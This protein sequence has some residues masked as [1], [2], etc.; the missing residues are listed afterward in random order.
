[1]LKLFQCLGKVGAVDWAPDPIIRAE[2]SNGPFTI[3]LS[4]ITQMSDLCSALTIRNRIS[5]NGYKLSRA[6]DMG[7]KTVTKME[8]GF[9]RTGLISVLNGF[10]KFYLCDIQYIDWKRNEKLV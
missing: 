10:Y 8:T 7:L 6:L 1:M 9:D 2:Y 5:I 4:L 3:T